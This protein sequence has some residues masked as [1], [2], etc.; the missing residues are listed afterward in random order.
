[1]VRT[2]PDCICPE[3]RPS[4][5]RVIKAG[6]LFVFGGLIPLQGCTLVPASDVETRLRSEVPAGPI[7]FNVAEG[8]A[9]LNAERAKRNLVGFQMDPRLQQAAQQHANRMGATGKYGHDIGPGT[10]FKSRIFSVGFEESAGENIGVGYGSIDEAIEGWKNSPEHR[11][12][13]FKSR[14]TLAGLAYAFNTSGQN[15]RY[16]HFWVLIMGARERHFS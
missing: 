7:N 5:R 8:F 4:R 3:Y 15:V 11:R 16:T 1:M 9:R 10:D 2:V 14:Y 12:N 6:S 13:M